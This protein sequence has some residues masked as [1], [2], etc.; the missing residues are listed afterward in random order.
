MRFP[1]KMNS[2]YVMVKISTIPPIAYRIFEIK[3]LILC[4]IYFKFKFNT[5]LTFN[6]F[7]FKLISVIFSGFIICFDPQNETEE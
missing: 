4:I 2:G 3:P 5:I 7:M 1:I 6:S